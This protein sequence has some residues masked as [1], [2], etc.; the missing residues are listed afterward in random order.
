MTT[1]KNSRS[2]R[3]RISRARNALINAR[4]S[5]GV[6]GSLPEDLMHIGRSI[7][8]E[9]EIIGKLIAL[10]EAARQPANKKASGTPQTKR[11]V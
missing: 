2:R 7:F 3:Y 11:S 5:I 1:D 6:L 9:Y 4:D 8:L 10:L